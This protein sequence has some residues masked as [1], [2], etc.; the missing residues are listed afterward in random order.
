[1]LTFSPD[2]PGVG[3][4]S[5]DPTY[6]SLYV[7]L[8]EGFV[9][10]LDADLTTIVAAT[11]LGGRKEDRILP[12]AL[13]KQ[14]HLY[15]AGVTYSDD[16]PGIGHQSAGGTYDQGGSY[17][18]GDGFIAKLDA[19]L[20]TILAATYVGTPSYDFITALVVD[21]QGAVYAA[22]YLGSW[23]PLLWGGLYPS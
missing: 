13:N 2:F 9:A 19:N 14:G 20:T 4:Q 17:D 22:G 8:A 10:K 15:F 18:S 1:G 12:L 11:Y 3:P 16:L 23:D 6:D 7:G 5:A 21:P